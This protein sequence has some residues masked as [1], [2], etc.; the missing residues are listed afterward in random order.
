[1]AKNEQPR[2][3]AHT[4]NDEVRR[5]PEPLVLDCNMPTDVLK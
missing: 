1:M 3:L 2:D 4:E 5:I